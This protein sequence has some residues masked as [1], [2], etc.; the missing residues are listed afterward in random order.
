MPNDVHAYIDAH[1]QT[2]LE[3][4]QT[5]LRIP[6]ISA[7]RAFDGE[8]RR[9]A[10]TVAHMLREQQLEHVTVIETAGAPLVYADWLAAEGKPTILLY[11]HY[12]VQPVDPESEWLTPPFEPTV[13][14]GYIYG[15]GV[16]D[17]K[18]QLTTTIHAVGALLASQGTLP[19]NVR[20]LIEGEE[21]SGGEAVEQYVRTHSEQLASD[22]AVIADG[23]IHSLTQPSIHYGC[24]GILYTEIVAHGAAHDL[25]SGGFG[26]NAPNPLFALAQILTGLK[27]PTGYITI[28]GLYELML[29]IPEEER[30]FWAQQGD[31]FVAKVAQEIE[32]ALVGEPGFS[33]IERAWARPTLEVHGFVGGFQ[34]EGAKT[35]IPAQ[36]RVKVSLRLVPGQTPENVLPLLQARVAALTP[37]GIRSEVQVIHAGMPFYTAPHGPVFRAAAQALK[38]E[39]GVAPWLSR[40]GG[41][42]P[43]SATMQEVLHTDT[44][45]L[46]FGLGS[47]GAHSA[48]E[49]THL[50]TFLRSVHAFARII[51][52]FGKLEATPA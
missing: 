30:T 7:L 4:Y 26:G 42:I 28:P 15:R 32:T 12:D 11:A 8:T 36:A 41:S 2:V 38:D 49:H 23:G 18:N 47:D 13:R 35:V 39:F 1:R 3:D 10:E 37:P 27:D 46:G 25:H 52:A 9:A 20:F 19:V 6:S 31:E 51:E 5:L 44:I 45:V 17:D 29:P 16:T 48:N 43:I 50:P 22:I 33:P 34:D 24:R 21:E 40:S 14:D